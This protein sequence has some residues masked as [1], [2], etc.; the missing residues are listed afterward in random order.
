MNS[1]FNQNKKAIFNSLSIFTL[2][3]GGVILLVFYYDFS[4]TNL[5]GLLF[6]VALTC[7]F[8]VAKNTYDMTKSS[9]VSREFG[10]ETSTDST[11]SSEQLYIQLYRNSPVPYLVL[12]LE[13]HVKSANIAA[14]RMFGVTQA[15][16]Q[17]INIF[18]RL[19]SDV[20]EHLDLLIEKYNGGRPVSG[21]IVKVK[22]TDNKEVWASLSLFSFVDAAGQRI[23]LLTL[24]DVTKQKGSEDAKS[25][26]VSLA[27][28]QLR[29]PIAGMK[30]SAELM[31]MDNSENLTERQHKYIDR[32]LMSIKRM[33]V[34]VDD[35]LRVSRFELGTFQPE[36]KPVVISA[37]FGDIMSDQAG[38][39]SQKNLV[40]KTFFDESIDTVITDPN[41]I[42]MIMA[43]LYANAVKYTHPG[44][45]I[46]FGFGKKDGNIAITMADNGIGIPIT[47]QPE[48]FSK[49]FRAANAVRDVPDGTGLGL[50]IARSA[51]V[52]L[53][54]NI[55]FTSTENTGTT[56][57]VVLPL[58]L[59]E[60]KLSY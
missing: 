50:Y 22:R 32:L 28:H 10:M 29:T 36:Y 6:I 25:A 39:V 18:S 5:G 58:E 45:T 19:Q 43:N 59:P 40:V 41:L 35:F 53:R 44:G 23:G 14:V 37:L 13:G 2:L 15:S 47:D 9:S 52:V 34:L 20:I 30:W 7:C 3:F 51:V 42:R 21:E 56:F 16:V 55:S 27:A 12:D 26:F 24:V 8:F 46:H 54:G 4:N 33:A 1:W 57:E 38:R 11:I 31:Q 60:K 17:G 49:L 48:V